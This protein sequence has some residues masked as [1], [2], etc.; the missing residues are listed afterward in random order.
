MES[1]VVGKTS[2]DKGVCAGRVLVSD[3]GGPS[4]LLEKLMD[5]PPCGSK[6][7]L[8]GAAVTDS[9][10]DCVEDWVNSIGQ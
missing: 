10:V 9:E 1:R 5:Q 4:L 7:P 2:A 8:I 6:M 3:S